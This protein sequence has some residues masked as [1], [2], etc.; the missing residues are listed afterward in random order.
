MQNYFNDIPHI[1]F[2]GPNSTNPLA[3]K[4]YD[5]NEIVAGKPMREQHIVRLHR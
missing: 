4:H 2:E 3:F 5:A 1:K